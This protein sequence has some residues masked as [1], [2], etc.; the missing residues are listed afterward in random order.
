MARTHATEE[1]VTSAVTLRSNREDV[2]SGVLCGSSPRLYDSTNRVQLMSA[3]QLRAAERSELFGGLL[4]FS[5]ELLLS[6][7]GS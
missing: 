2:A 7:T 6:E 3:V 1:H 4:Q 5:R